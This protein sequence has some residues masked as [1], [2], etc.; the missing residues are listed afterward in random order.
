ME[1]LGQRIARARH[2]RG[3]TLDA[4]AREVGVHKSTIQRYEKVLCP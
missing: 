4:V 2:I 3:L 1:T